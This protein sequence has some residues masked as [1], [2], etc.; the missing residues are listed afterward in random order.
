[1]PIITLISSEGSVM[2]KARYSR[3]PLVE[4]IIIF[5]NLAYTVAKVILIEKS[6]YSSCALVSVEASKIN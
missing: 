3:V 2:G 4:D 6:I 5:K 1:L